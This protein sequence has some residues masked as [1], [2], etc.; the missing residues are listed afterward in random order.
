MHSEFVERRARKSATY[1]EAL[2]RTLQQVDLALMIREIREDAGLTQGDFAR[3]MGT[4]Q[5][6]IADLE[7]AE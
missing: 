4:T 5:S 2:A 3:Q 6:V 7:D 1:R